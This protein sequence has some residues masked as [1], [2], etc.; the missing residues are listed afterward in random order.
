MGTRPAE[1]RVL[2]PQLLIIFGNPE[3]LLKLS[4]SVNPALR[5]TIL[6]YPSGALRANSNYCHWPIPR[7]TLLSLLE[8]GATRRHNSLAMACSSQVD[9][10]SLMVSN[11]IQTGPLL[12]NHNLPEGTAPAG[13]VA[14]FH[15]VGVIFILVF[16]Y[17]Y[18]CFGFPLLGVF[19][20]GWYV[21]TP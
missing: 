10:T 19:R 14:G 2:R 3:T 8:G 20:R 17:L 12:V 1:Y 6:F 13:R 4:R 15:L 16:D 7:T 5:W 11:N 9:A 21:I 18:A